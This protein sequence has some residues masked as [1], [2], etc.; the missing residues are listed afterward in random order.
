MSGLSQDAFSS[1][2]NHSQASLDFVKVSLVWK[3][4]IVT[5]P[6]AVLYD[7]FGL[8]YAHAVLDH[9]VHISD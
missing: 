1:R 5:S 9:L 6:S 3:L 2:I 7:G 4:T 8:F